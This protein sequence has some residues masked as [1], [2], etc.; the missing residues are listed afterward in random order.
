MIIKALPALFIAGA[1]FAVMSYA[2]ALLLLA[3][4]YLASR[5]VACQVVHRHIE[6]PQFSKARNTHHDVD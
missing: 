6:Y 4:G 3:I 5:R 1:F 2:R